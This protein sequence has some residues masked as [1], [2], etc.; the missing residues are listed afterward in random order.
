M[1]RYVLE[2]SSHAARC[3][4]QFEPKF[5]CATPNAM[6]QGEERKARNGLPGHKRAGQMKRIQGANGLDRERAAGSID[7]ISCESQ[8]RP[9][10]GGPVQARSFVSSLGF[11]QLP[12]TNGTDERPMTFKQRQVGRQDDVCSSESR[13]DLGRSGFIEKP[14]ENSARFSI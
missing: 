5:T 12:D 10:H 4:H 13:A 7:N 14:R 6:I 3:W 9:V 8:K 11:G 1:E 2:Y